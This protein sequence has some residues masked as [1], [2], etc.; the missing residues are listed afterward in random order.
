M[1]HLQKEQIGNLLQVIPITDTVISK[2]VTEIP[3][4]L[5]DS[6]SG[7]LTLLFEFIF[8]IQKSISDNILKR[9]SSLD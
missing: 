2:R 6:V 8:E 5:Y 4:L 9:G 3:D 7:H 1:R